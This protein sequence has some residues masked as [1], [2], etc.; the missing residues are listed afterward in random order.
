MPARDEER[1]RTTDGPTRGRGHALVSDDDD[2]EADDRSSPS[3]EVVYKAILHEGE[4]ELE[5]TSSALAWSGLAAG[6]SMGFSFVGV[7]LLRSFLPDRPWVPLVSSAGYPLGFL[8]VILG[9]QQ[10]F[11]E[12]TLTVML[13][14][15]RRKDLAT[16]GNVLRLWAIV[17]AANVVGAAGFAAILAHSQA[18]D[19]HVYETLKLVARDAAMPSFAVSLLR[20][21]FAGWM[22]ALVVWLL[23]FAETARV[24]VIVII[25]YAV[26]LAHLSHV[27]VSTVDAS[28]LVFVGESSWSELVTHAFVPALLGNIV[29]GVTLVAA[30]NHAQVVAGGGVD[31]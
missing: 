5:R 20:G 11:T 10:L 3:G 15:F 9:R 6:L 19:D 31:V 24:W 25:T 18:V 7:G 22:I 26:G 12:N 13:P 28:F 23:P 8:I 14:L 17:L 30:L 27:I 16:L 4:S 29:G 21:I 2:S 1:D